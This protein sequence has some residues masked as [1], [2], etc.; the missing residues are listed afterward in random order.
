[1]IVFMDGENLD[2]CEPFILIILCEV[3]V[4]RY[5]DLQKLLVELVDLNFV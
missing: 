2:A 1:M 5:Q 4:L 3:R